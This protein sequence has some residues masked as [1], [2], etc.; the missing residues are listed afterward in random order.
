LGD[1]P[2]THYSGA[3]PVSEMKLG[4]Y[5]AILGRRKWWVVL[6]GLGMLIATTVM[7]Y[8][9]PNVYRAETVILVN[10]AEVPDKYV[11]TIVTADIAARLT[12]LQQQVLSPTRLKKLVEAEGL[13]PTPGGK[14]TEEDVIHSVQKSIV[15][16][17]VNAAVGKM[18]VF[19]IAY[20][21]RKREE[22]ARIANRLAQMFIEV[23]TQAREDQTQGTAEF[24]NSQLQETKQQL[25]Q[26]DAQLRAIKSQ[27]IVD[28][29]ESKPYHMEA[30]AN[31][32][33]QLQGIQDKIAQDERDKGLLQSMLA[34]GGGAA[35]TVNVD[36]GGAPGSPASPYQAEIE[37]LESKL[38]DLRARYGPGHPDV[39]RAQNELT[40]LRNKAAAEPQVGQGAAVA[41]QKP[42]IQPADRRR[43]PV[44]EAQ[45][46]KLDEEIKEQRTLLQPL[47]EREDF[48][49]AKLQ[50]EPV[51]EQQIARL[52]QDYDILRTQ[53]SQLLE[54]EKAAEI[55]HALEVRQKGEHFEVLDAAVTPEKPAAPNR[56][57]ISIGGLFAGLI[58]GVGMIAAAEMNDDSVST[59]HEAARIF[60]KPVLTGVPQI[61]SAE[62]RSAWRLRATGAL[63]GTVVG[64]AIFG[65]TLAV[66][67]E[68]FF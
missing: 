14:R 28:L 43:N 13:Y 67:S 23:N 44:L 57:L 41:D 33:V 34:S 18:G 47:Q 42:A 62:E 38:A 52:Q 60:S 56:L 39:R 40:R 1:N 29:P 66:L 9:L 19:R 12:T 64:S 65:V 24:L 17:T 61:V 5:V 50:Q 27:N 63:V 25:D 4:D 32:R 15:V 55:S 46:Q 22:V 45:I 48:H 10:S 31:L 30:L 68:K 7:A 8:R 49:T 6:S 2:S 36:N 54:K 59:E 16:E 37:K 21:G 20:S 58:L 51:F 11:A 26:K 35:P 3:E 53:Y